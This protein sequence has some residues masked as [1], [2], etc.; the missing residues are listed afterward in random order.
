[1]NG[2]TLANLLL[3]PGARRYI[4]TAADDLVGHRSIICLLPEV[5]D[6]DDVWQSL[7]KEV[8]HRD[9]YFDIREIDLSEPVALD[10]IGALY[11]ELGREEGI[12]SC[13]DLEEIVRVEP[14]PDIV[15][16]RGYGKVPEERR[17]RWVRLL[18]DWVEISKRMADGGA[19]P[20][21]LCL[22]A[23]ADEALEE[24]STDVLLTTHCWWGF[25]SILETRIALRQMTTP[26]MSSFSSIWRE[27]LIPAIAG[28][29]PRF[30]S[31]LSEE[32]ELEKCS[33]SR[34]CTEYA[35]S[36]GWETEQLERWHAQDFLRRAR[37]AS[38]DHPP[39]D[40]RRLWAAGVLQFTP[41]RGA[42]IHTAALEVMGLTARV[43]HRIWRGQA[44][45]L[46]PTLELIR[47]RICEDFVRRHGRDWPLGWLAPETEEEEDQVRENPLACS[48]GYLCA[49][50]RSHI[51]SSE[52]R[53][54]VSFAHR[55][56][57]VRNA[58]AHG[59]LVR[60][61]PAETLWNE[62]ASRGLL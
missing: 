7:L 30:L 55:A 6:A 25:P 49:V 11:H 27:H 29:D 51:G 21:A 56:K 32:C 45:F 38:A 42:E 8:W 44:E 37:T 3:T 40:G 59:G 31:L 10:P 20:T 47:L 48:W 57:A 26:E 2:R 5:V 4:E 14:R 22:V 34:S 53:D 16:L 35:R 52:D 12:V 1:M 18:S 19:R 36:R 62:A 23:P 61:Q 15:Y 39:S 50:L 17:H 41:E 58:L 54:L 46:L 60:R 33:V 28:P 13:G 9:S 24:V 43:L